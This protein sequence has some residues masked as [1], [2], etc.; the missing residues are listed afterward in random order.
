VTHHDSPRT[1][2]DLPSRSEDLVVP[3]VDEQQAGRIY[4]PS[5]HRWALAGALAGAVLLGLLGWA[6]AAGVLPLAGLG[7]WA[8]AGPAVGA[9]TGA[10]LGV[11]GGGLAGALLALYRLPPRQQPESL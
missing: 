8:A 5:I 1:E 2:H 7:Q 11:A 6:V 3:L 9:F 4:D 10:G